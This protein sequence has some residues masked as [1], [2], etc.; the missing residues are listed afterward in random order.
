MTLFFLSL[1][2]LGW[3]FRPDWKPVFGG[4][5]MG[6]AGGFLVSL[7]L[8]WKVSAIAARAAGGQRSRFG[9]FG[10]VS[11]AAIGVLAAVI[12]V[13]YLEFNLP[14]TAAGLLAGP[15]VTLILG[16]SAISR[17]TGG[18]ASDERGEKQ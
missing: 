14:A 9:M 15:L 3:A 12:S 4:F 6:V 8:A 11:R 2:C 5:L 13:R 17:Q 16:L 7:H 10:F 18:H 1:G